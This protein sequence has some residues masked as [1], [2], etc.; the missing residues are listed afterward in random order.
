MLRYICSC[1]APELALA[2]IPCKVRTLLISLLT[3]WLVTNIWSCKHTCVLIGLGVQNVKSSL[4]E[5]TNASVALS[6]VGILQT[7]VKSINMEEEN[8]NKSEEDVLP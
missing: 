5:E 7:N 3:H 2:Y 4:P 1:I 6:C 8:N